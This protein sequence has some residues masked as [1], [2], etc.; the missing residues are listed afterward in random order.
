MIKYT[1]SQFNVKYILIYA[2]F[3]LSHSILSYL[4]YFYHE[5]CMIKSLFRF[6]SINLNFDRAY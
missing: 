5:F 1:K 2:N 4:G 6:Y 3:Y